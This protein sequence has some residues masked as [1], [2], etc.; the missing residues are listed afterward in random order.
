MAIHRE[1]SQ[2][3]RS[4]RHVVPFWI[5]PLCVRVSAAT[6]QWK[7]PGRQD[8]PVTPFVLRVLSVYGHCKVSIG[9]L[10]INSNSVLSSLHLDFPNMC[11]IDLSIVCSFAI[12]WNKTNLVGLLSYG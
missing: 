8:K 2:D 6:I 9:V 3:K 5:F 10:F 11:H 4:E 12:E 7:T 1:Y